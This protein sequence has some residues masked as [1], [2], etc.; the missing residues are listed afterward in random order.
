LV[1]SKKQEVK[2]IYQSSSPKNHNLIKNVLLSPSNRLIKDKDPV[3]FKRSFEKSVKK[4]N[5]PNPFDKSPND[6]IPNEKSPNDKSP[7]NK[8]PPKSSLKY[9]RP[10]LSNLSPSLEKNVINDD[11]NFKKLEYRSHFKR[12]TQ[13]KKITNLVLKNQQE[14]STFSSKKDDK[15]ETPSH[16]LRKGK[17]TYT[18]LE[19]LLKE[20]NEKEENKINLKLKIIRPNPLKSNESAKNTIIIPKEQI[21][22]KKSSPS[23]KQ[24]SEE[25]NNALL[26]GSSINFDQPYFHKII[27]H[28]T[29]K[30]DEYYEVMEEVPNLKLSDPTNNVVNS[31]IL[32]NKYAVISKYRTLNDDLE[33]LSQNDISI[34][35]NLLKVDRFWLSFKKNQNEESVKEYHD[36][37][38]QDYILQNQANLVIYCIFNFFLTMFWIVISEEL[39]GFNGFFSTRIAMLLIAFIFATFWTKTWLTGYHKMFV[40]FFY[41]VTVTQILLFTILNPYI[42]IVMELEFLACYISLTKYPFIGFIE[43]SVISIIFLVLHIIYL[44][45]IED[46]YYLMLHSTFV[47]ILFDLGSVHIRIKTLIDNFNNS[48]INFIKKKQLNNLIVNLLPNHVFYFKLF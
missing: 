6:K 2:A 16:F 40:L 30:L 5:S 7:N 41:A 35:K 27:S 48:R 17:K 14:I 26:V 20:K 36:E 44:R 21:E 37:I 8:P 38:H 39:T 46:P 32:G 12:R 43:S 33:D 15:K 24:I 18:D 23:L 31:K 42:E 11:S 10:N 29:K 47:I 22:Q 34:K 13:I 1:P 25:E 28:G 4:V 19:V 9:N 45:I 3:S